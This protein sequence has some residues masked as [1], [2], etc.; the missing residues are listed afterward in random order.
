V[1]VTV[2]FNDN[3]LKAHL[4]PLL[5]LPE[6]EEVVLVAD[7][8]PPPLPKV[9][10]ELPP[11]RLVRFVGRAAAKLFVCMRIALRERPDWVLGFN[12]VP[13]GANAIVTARA[14]RSRS[15]YTMIGG[16]REWLQGGW[17]SDNN[18]LGRL[19]RPVPLLERIM[20]RLIAR[21]TRIATMGARGRRA[22]IERGMDPTR[23]IVIP[24]AIDVDRFAPSRR[25]E[26]PYGVITVGELIGRKRTSDLVRVTA[27][28]VHDHPDLRV[29]VVGEGPLEGELRRLADELGVADAIDF[30]G[31][32]DDL[33]TLYAQADIF[34]LP[35]AY[36]GLS[37]AM[38]EAM[39][40]GLP[41]VVSDVGE[42]GGFVREGE[43]GRLHA[44]GDLDALARILR[45]LL[46]DP[47]LRRSMGAAAAEDVRA[48]VS[49]DAVAASYRKLFAGS[50]EPIAS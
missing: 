38:L 14:A 5:A 12:L 36:E 6:V 40:S 22:L 49:V 39:A 21:S 20:L 18:I 42:I 19:G 23:V 32:R 24:P 43:T 16:D 34:V 8:P 50:R 2:T 4:L 3:Q 28:L 46:D 30:L 45:E 41:A 15:L 48:H 9:R 27:R 31:F 26:T 25:D 7:T 13:H 47:D 33:E 29:A 1:L 17:K 44:P 11:P 35:S 37:I 10:T